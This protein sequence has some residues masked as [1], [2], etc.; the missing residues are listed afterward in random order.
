MDLIKI[1]KFKAIC[2]GVR[3]FSVA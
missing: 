1:F 2:N 3:M